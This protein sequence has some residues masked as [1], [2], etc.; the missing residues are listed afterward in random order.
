MSSKKPALVA[1]SKPTHNPALPKVAITLN[2]AQYY[3]EFDFN[4]IAVAEEA[5]GLNLFGTFDFTNLSVIKYRAMLFASLLKNHPKMT[6][7]RA[8]SFVTIHT[9]PE[10]TLK[11]VEAWH[12]SRPEVKE[13]EGNVVAE[14][15]DP[16][17]INKN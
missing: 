2:E 10:I 4:A 12:G 5:T 3:L 11:L 17:D 15:D 6:L 16:L 8:G 13:A 9:L 7:E 14:D 1:G